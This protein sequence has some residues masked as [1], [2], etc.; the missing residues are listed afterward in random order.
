MVESTG[1]NVV[2]RTLNLSLRGKEGRSWSLTVPGEVK[3]RGGLVCRTNQPFLYLNTR[4]LMDSLSS[5]LQLSLSTEAPSAEQ[6]QLTVSLVT[7]QFEW[8]TVNDVR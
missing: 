6:F 4:E 8:G 2:R 7:N 1:E 3:R 5:K